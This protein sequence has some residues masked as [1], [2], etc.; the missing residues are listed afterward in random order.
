MRHR[1]ADRSIDQGCGEPA[2]GNTGKLGTPQ[3]YTDDS[4]AGEQTSGAD[5]WPI[6][7]LRKQRKAIGERGRLIT[8]LSGGGGG[9][10]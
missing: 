3:R 8:N 1:K 2:S 10:G 6:E 5:P 9:D 7:V 4:S